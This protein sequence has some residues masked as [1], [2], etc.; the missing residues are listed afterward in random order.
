MGTRPVHSKPLLGPLPSLA[1]SAEGFRV[2]TNQIAACCCPC[3]VYDTE[4]LVRVLPPT[5]TWER[6]SKDQAWPL[7]NL[8][9]V[10]ND[11]SPVQRTYC[12]LARLPWPRHQ[13]LVQAKPQPQAL[14]DPI[15]GWHA[16]NETHSLDL[17]QGR[18]VIAFW[19]LSHLL[20]LMEQEESRGVKATVFL[21]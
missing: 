18:A 19:V 9:A 14:P 20:L 2:A 6:A 15:R 21:S 1:A 13:A 12:L 16:S 5:D 7:N 17:S 8:Q 11:S 4:D 3:L 10:G